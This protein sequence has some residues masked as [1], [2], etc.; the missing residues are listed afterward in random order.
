MEYYTHLPWAIAVAAG[1]LAAIIL[2]QRLYT[3]ALLRRMRFG[4]PEATAIARTEIPAEIRLILEETAPELEALGFEYLGSFQ[5]RPMLRSGDPEPIYSCRYFNRA[6]GCVAVIFPSDIPEPGATASVSFQ[7]LLADGRML[8]TVNRK[9]YQ[10][11]PMPDRYLLDDGYLNTIADQWALHQR[12]VADDGSEIV[13]DAEQ[14]RRYDDDILRQLLDHWLNIGFAELAEKGTVRL[15]PSGARSFLRDM[16]AGHRRLTKLPRMAG[17]ESIEARIAADLRAYYVNESLIGGGA[18]GRGGKSVLFVVS[19]AIGVVAF[20]LF[21]SWEMAAILLLVLLFHEFGHALAMRATGH[22]NVQVLVLPLLGAV[23]SGRKDDA[24]PWARLFVLLAGPAPGL[25]IAV[26]CLYAAMAVSPPH[27]LLLQLGLLALFLNLFNL[28]PLI[29]L[30]GGRIIELFLFS[31][32]PFLRFVFFLASIVGL[33]G[34]GMW[35][36]SHVLLALAIVLAVVLRTMWRQFRLAAQIG[37]VDREAAPRAILTAMH[38][39][40]DK[41]LKN[42][43]R[44]LQDVRMLLPLVVARPPRIWESVLGLFLYVAVIV[45]PLIAVTPLV[46]V[47]QLLAGLVTPSSDV[48][49]PQ[50]DW[51][52]ELADATTPEERWQVLI[53]AAHW[54]EDE[55]ENSELAHKRYQQAWK[56][57]EAFPADDLRRLDVR[58]ALVRTGDPERV[59]AGFTDMLG[60]LR[61]LQGEERYRLAEMLEEMHWR[62]RESPQTERIARLREAIAVRAKLREQHPYQAAADHQEI[63]RLLYQEG[64]VPGAETELRAGLKAYSYPYGVTALAWLLINN[65]RPTEAEELLQSHLSEAG[66]TAYE[67]DQVL[68]WARWEQNDHAGAR[69]EMRDL[70]ADTQVNQY[71]QRFP[72]LLDLVYFNADLPEEHKRWS[73]QAKEEIGDAQYGADILFSSLEYADRGQPWLSRQTEVRRAVFQEL[74][75]PPSTRATRCAPD[76]GEQ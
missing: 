41:A 37:N 32:W 34:L 24:G 48:E 72:L 66:P 56:I 19:A 9:Q 44:R 4:N 16:I 13:A 69:R 8:V 46:P 11:L 51:D 73:V 60:E 1:L 20:G 75:L 58:I 12:R 65:G 71:W 35:L 21:F 67:L 74:G 26:I 39:L 54:A 27:L 50:R 62:D 76:A 57:A 5:T 30:D 49:M 63:A 53:A 40:P 36:D 2:G 7:T 28:L 29:P 55:E 31:R 68:A 17:S 33:A 23:A 22:R 14:V 47:Q 64:D 42:F 45:L 52:A 18:F 59:L 61:A 3:Y 15:T 6:T 70:L 38:Q 43:H 10:F 25:V